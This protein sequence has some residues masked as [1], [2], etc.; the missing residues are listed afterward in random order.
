MGPVKIE[1]KLNDSNWKNW[2]IEAQH[3]II[4]ADP[5]LWEIVT[6]R[7]IQPPHHQALERKVFDQKNSQVLYGILSATEEKLRHLINDATSDTANHGSAY[8]AW[9]SL[10]SHFQRMDPYAQTKAIKRICDHRFHCAHGRS[11]RAT[12]S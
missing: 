4:G 11:I 8:V 6:G 12:S 1:L 7:S 3:A 2:K 9:N 10:Q 5:E